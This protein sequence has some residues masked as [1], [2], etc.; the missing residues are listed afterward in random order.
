M[1]C[2]F[3]RPNEWPSLPLQV[4]TG[5]T[6]FPQ[7]AASRRSST[8]L[9]WTGFGFAVLTLLGFSACALSDGS[10]KTSLFATEAAV[11]PFMGL[12]RLTGLRS[13]PAGE[14]SDKDSGRREVA[15]LGLG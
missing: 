9:V 13:S 14:Q 3:S 5:Q 6:A 11:N 10:S 2:Q 8:R 15:T 12:T 4:E 7:D 1:L